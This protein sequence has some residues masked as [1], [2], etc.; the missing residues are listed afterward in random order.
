MLNS[1]I[2]STCP[3][4]MA[5][6]GPL[7]AEISLAVWGIPAHLL[8]RVSRLGS[9]T[10]RHSSSGWVLAKLCGIEQRAPLI[11]LIFN[12]AA[13]TLGIGPHSS[14]LISLGLLARICYCCVTFKLSTNYP[15]SRDMNSCFWT[16]VNP[17][18]VNTCDTLV[19]NTA[20]EVK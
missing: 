7:T 10:A 19:T 13:I 15:C 6:A 8:Q 11:L 12:R 14:S 20:R 1:N 18:C 16:P 3:H 5:N 4:N 9:V 2:S 17:A